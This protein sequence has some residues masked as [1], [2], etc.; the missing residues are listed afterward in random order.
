MRIAARADDSRPIQKDCACPVCSDYSRGYIRHLLATKEFTGGRLLSMHNLHYTLDLLR[1][2]RAAI[3]V[4]DLTQVSTQI[5]EDRR[6]GHH[7]SERGV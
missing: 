4:G 2:L 3:V 1:R 5:L 6:S 7:A